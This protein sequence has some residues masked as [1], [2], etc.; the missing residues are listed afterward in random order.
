MP[1]PAKELRLRG[2]AVSPGIAMGNAYV[3]RPREILAPNYVVAPE[4]VDEELRRFHA[5]LDRAREEIRESRMRL[6]EKIGE[7]HAKIFD[8]HLLILEDTKAIDDTETLVRQDLMC[9]EFAFNR[10]IG[11]ILESFDSIGDSYLR[12]RRADVEDVRRRVLHILI[13]LEPASFGA[14]NAESILISRELSPSDTAMIDRRYVLGVA[15]ELGGRTSHAAILARSY[16]IPAVVGLEGL[17]DQVRHGD[18]ILIDGHAGLV[19]L[20]PTEA[21]RKEYE[22]ARQR[23]HELERELLTLKDYPAITR[24]GRKIEL[25]ANVKT[26]EDS[27]LALAKGA[28]GVGL[29]RTEWFFL[30]RDALPSEEE[31]VQQYTQI[32]Q[33]IAPDPVIFRA[34]DI[35]GDKFASYLGPGKSELNPFLGWRGIRFLLT[36]RDILRTQLRAF[37][38]ASVAGKVKVMFPMITGLEEVRATRALV[39]EVRR[40]LQEENR[41]F[42]PDIE[43]GLMIETPAAVAIADLLA[44]ETDFFSIGS[45]DLVQYT[46]AVDRSNARISYLYEPMHPSVLRLVRNTVD[47]GHAQGIWVGMCGEIAGDPLYSVLLVGLGLDELSISAYMIPEVKRIIRGITYDEAKMLARKALGLSTAAEIRRLVSSVMHERFPEL[48]AAETSEEAP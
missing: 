13:G 43:V 17:C 1:R 9:A 21:S 14:L 20:R 29:Y 35:G 27:E 11:R 22:E 34:L 30:T 33:A 2:V 45:N 8:A 48:V 7:D 41:P 4:R 32:A 28:K 12:E 47:A 3:Q 10:V 37:L 18:A 38:R 31:Q 44:Q 24:D 19:V 16:G 5:A 25:S 26:P 40:E 46:L 36:R 42:D 15:T 6:A 23:F 39:D